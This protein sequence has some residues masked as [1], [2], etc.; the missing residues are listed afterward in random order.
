MLTLSISRDESKLG[1]SHFMEEQ[2]YQQSRS[3]LP[4]ALSSGDSP[5]RFFSHFFSSCSMRCRFCVKS[6][7]IQEHF[8]HEQLHCDGKPTKTETAAVAEE[9]R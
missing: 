9:Q 3:C 6:F 5:S 8:L 7:S 1:E 2:K 4:L